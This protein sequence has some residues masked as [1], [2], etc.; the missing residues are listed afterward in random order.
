MAPASVRV[1]PCTAADAQ[2]VVDVIL[3]IQRSEFGIPITIEDQPDLR[4]IA[5]FYQHGRGGFW[6]AESDG[7][8]VGTIALLDIGSGQAALRKMFVAASHRGPAHG[9]AAQLLATLLESC[10]RGD[11]QEVYLGTTDAFVAAHR[12]YEKHG[13]TRL[14]RSEL[15]R[16]FPI[17]AVDTRFYVRRLR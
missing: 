5:A 14:D 3:P 15:P 6:V 11:I 2:A 8:V 13:F 12:F 9:V 1:R 16:A 7:A 17:M 4:D 10:R